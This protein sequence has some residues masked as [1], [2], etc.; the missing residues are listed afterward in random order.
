MCGRYTLL[1]IS[2]L[3][4]RFR[5]TDLGPDESDTRI[6]FRPRYN[7][8][9]SQRVPVMVNRDGAPELRM[10]TWGCQPAWGRPG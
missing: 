5:F 7:I 1:Q 3:Q 9:P 2:F 8:A 10:M 6:P 4:G